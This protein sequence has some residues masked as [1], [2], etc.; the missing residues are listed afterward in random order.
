MRQ[1]RA[2]TAKC[3]DGRRPQHDE[4]QSARRCVARCAMMR[5]KE[6]E[7]LRE[8]AKRRA[9]SA[10]RQTI[11]RAGSAV[12]APSAQVVCCCAFSASVRSSA[13]AACSGK[14]KYVNSILPLRVECVIEAHI[15]PPYA[16]DMQQRGACAA[17]SIRHVRSLRLVQQ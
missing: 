2:N 4:A 1:Q 5:A 11:I 8:E 15:L 12:D 13:Q 16:E 9:G 14:K 17:A 7:C 3:Y 6:R 10:A